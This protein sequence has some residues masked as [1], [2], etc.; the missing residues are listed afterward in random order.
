MRKMISNYQ[1][2]NYKVVIFDDGTKIRFNDKDSL[3]PSFP[4]SMDVKI[5]NYCPFNCPQC[6]EGSSEQGEKGKI[7]NHPFLKTLHRGTELAI[8]GGAVTYHQDLIPFL[9]Q[10]K[11][12][13]LIPS[14]TINQEEYDE[15]K[16]NVLVDNELIYGLGV[17]F[18]HY[19][20]EVWDKILEI[21][22]AVVHLIAGYHSPDVFRYFADKG[23]KILILGYK[24]WGRGED[25]LQK[26][27]SSIK[28]GIE[29]VR[30]MLPTLFTK[31]KVVSFDN[32]SLEQ[33]N[34][35]EIIGEERWKEFYMGGDG[36]Y[37]MYVDLVKN[38]CAKSS[39]S[40]ERFPLEMFDKVWESLKMK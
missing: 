7:L 2:G 32:L 31:C 3:I 11:E 35:R 26:H 34:V 27:S 19:D 13:G 30:K 28:S 5:S 37:T 22:N 4:E 25:Y 33:L 18:T 24:N 39:T 8:G 6:H 1:N 36:Q 20:S 10:L 23:A 12:Y 9:K 40:S 16:I 38:E 15:T 21:P 29:E 14:I 17:S